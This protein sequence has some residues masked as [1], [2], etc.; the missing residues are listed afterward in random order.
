MLCSKLLKNAERGRLARWVDDRFQRI[1][2]GYG[3]WLDW[4]LKKPLLPLL[5]VAA[6]RRRRHNR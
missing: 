6:L 4:T 1:E 5:G 3:R 2:H